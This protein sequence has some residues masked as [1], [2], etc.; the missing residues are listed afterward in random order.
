MQTR[1]H[2]SIR[3]NRPDLFHF[4]NASAPL[5]VP[6][7]YVLTIHDASLFVYR[8]LHPK[9]RLVAIRLMLPWVARRAAA[10][11]TVSE[12]AR[13]ELLRLLKLPPEKMFAIHEAAPAHYR[14]LTDPNHRRQ[15]K[16][17]YKLPDAFVLH[18]GTLEPRKNLVRL[19][20]ALAELHARGHHATLVLAGPSGWKME[21]F[22]EHVH[23]FGLGEYVRWL[24]YV[25]EPDLPGLYSLARLF[26]YP[27]LYEGFGLPPLEAMACGLPVLS[28][29]ASAL[30]EVCGDAALLIN[31]LDV[32]EIANGLEHLW[33]NESAR[34]E[35]IQRG[36]VRAASF[37]WER[38]AR[39]TM[40]V[41]ERALGL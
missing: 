1:L 37:S 10:I 23:S 22:Y 40:T 18:V 24:G 17:K 14:P 13:L 8:E 4:T 3:Q 35:L 2:W 30:S 12:H 21:G 7:P 9:A 25:P 6:C 26:A 38:T 31:P 36:L 27:S 20:A 32:G 34:R 15:L 28:S 29:S 41:Y 16:E 5:V 33:T 39:E 19:V 11:I